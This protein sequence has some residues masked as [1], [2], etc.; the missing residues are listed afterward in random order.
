[1]EQYVLVKSK[2]ELI[3][4]SFGKIYRSIL[5]YFFTNNAY[6]FNLFAKLTNPTE[7]NLG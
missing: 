1:M 7:T 5:K 3:E 2:N 4:G 6:C